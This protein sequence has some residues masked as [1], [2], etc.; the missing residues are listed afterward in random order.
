[1]NYLYLSRGVN[2]KKMAFLTGPSASDPD[3]NSLEKE[4]HDA[5]ENGYLYSSGSG[6]SIDED[7]PQIKVLRGI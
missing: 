6:F 1:M 3:R 2:L 4:I 5:E 7:D